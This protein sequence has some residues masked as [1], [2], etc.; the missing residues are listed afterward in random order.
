MLKSIFT[1]IVWTFVFTTIIMLS[2]FWKENIFLIIYLS[3]KISLFIFSPGM[4]IMKTILPSSSTISI[5]L[6]GTSTGILLSGLIYYLLGLFGI[7]L[8]FSIYTSPILIIGISLLFLN[9]KKKEEIV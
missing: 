5:G 3:L 6:M 2:T 4:F 7:P 9:M 8:L 1:P